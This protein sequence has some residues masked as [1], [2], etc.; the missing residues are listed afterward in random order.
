MAQ[1]SCTSDA[2]AGRHGSWYLGAYTENGRLAGELVMLLLTAAEM[3]QKTTT[4]YGAVP[5]FQ[6]M[7][8]TYLP[9]PSG[10]GVAGLAPLAARRK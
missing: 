5:E 2:T 1:H 8:D 9:S 6:E 3:F 7:N 10:S 4:D